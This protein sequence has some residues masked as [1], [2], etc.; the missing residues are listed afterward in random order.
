MVLQSSKSE[1]QAKL[2]NSR[3]MGID[4]MKKRVSCQAVDSSTSGSGEIDIG[5]A[6][7]TNQVVARIAG[8]RGVVDSKLRVV[9]NVECFSAELEVP[10]PEDLEM[11][12]ERNVEI[13]TAWIAQEIPAGIP[14]RQTARSR[15][16]PRIQ[17]ERSESIRD[18]LLM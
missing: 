7:A 18:N 13:E 3:I 6:V 10:L 9:E 17:K 16:G 12:Q 14:E 2:E 15:E 5:P 4:W 1:L 11:L 8:V